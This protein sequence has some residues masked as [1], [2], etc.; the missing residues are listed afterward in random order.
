MSAQRKAEKRAGSELVKIPRAKYIFITGGVV[1]SLGKGITSAS[2]ALLLKSRGYKVATL[3]AD[4]YLNVDPG[5][6][7]PFQHGEVYVTDDGAETDLDLGHYERF[8]DISMSKLNNVTSGQIYEQVIEN[9]R[10]GRYLGGTVQVIPHVTDEIIRNICNLAKHPPRPDIVITEVGGTVGDIESLPFFEA[11]RQF[12]LRAGRRN[13]LFIHVTLLPYIS[14]A[15]EVKTKPTQHSVNKL[16]EIGLQPDIIVCRT[17][18]PV[19]EDVRNK[20]ALFCNVG[21]KD[22]IEARTVKTI[23]QIPLTLEKDGLANSVLK[24][25]RLKDKPVDLSDWGDR[26]DAI[27][28]P[29]QEVRLAVCGKYV[30][31]KD[32]YKSISEAFIHAGAAHRTRVNVDW[33]EAEDVQKLGPDKIFEGVH[34]ILVPGGFGNRGIE[35]KIAAV[36]YAREQGIPYFGICLG[37]QIAVIEFARNAAGMRTANSTEFRTTKTP[38]IDLMPGQRNIHR[39]GGTMRLGSWA[40]HLQR[41]TKAFEAYGTE[42]IHERH[43]HRYEFNNRYKER[44]EEKGMVFAGMNP[45]TELV[46][47]IELKNHPWFVGCQFHPE[48][49]SRLTNPHPL[50]YRFVEAA[51]RHAAENGG[52]GDM[53]NDGD[54]SDASSSDGRDKTKKTAEA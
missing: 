22:V 25:L 26:V 51:V 42:L 52:L 6:M 53:V 50:F 39:K 13:V 24:K 48:L 8:T 49:K 43:R 46:E 30:G 1:S 19:D 15:D 44:L 40:C 10:E 27:H 14:A 34:G 4:P 12:S 54:V 38:V 45:D 17:E 41:G 9:E 16:R 23:Y 28:R 21:P 20:I 2:L 7:N 3:K 33:V 35:G 31:L 37:L 11:F 36:R 18:V 5:T 47:M 29:E 32:A